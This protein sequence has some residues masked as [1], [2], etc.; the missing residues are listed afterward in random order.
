MGVSN[1]QHKFWLWPE[2]SNKF[3]DYKKGTIQINV[4]DPEILTVVAAMQAR[5]STTDLAHKNGF[6][7]QP[8][9]TVRYGFLGSPEKLEKWLQCIAAPVMIRF[10]KTAVF[11]PSSASDDAAVVYIAVDSDDLKILHRGIDVAAQFTRDTFDYSPHL[12][13]AYVK[14]S[15]ASKY[16]G[17]ASLQGRIFRATEVMIRPVPYNVSLGSASLRCT[18]NDGSYYAKP[19]REY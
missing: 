3:F 4:T 2:C 8:H 6:E 16:I 9:I 18:K 15:E 5:I 1:N 17:D 7:L 11:D 13:L 14:P 10:G 12:T 19:E